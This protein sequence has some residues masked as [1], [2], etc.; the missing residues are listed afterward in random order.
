MVVVKKSRE[1]QSILQTVKIDEHEYE[2]PV[3]D[4]VT[5][6]RLFPRRRRGPQHLLHRACELWPR[7]D[8]SRRFVDCFGNE[9]WEFFH[10]R[11]AGRLRVALTLTTGS[12]W[13]PH[14]DHP[15]PPRVRA[16]QGVPAAGHGLFLDRTALVDDSAEI[17]LAA[18][19]LAATGATGAELMEAI[20]GWVYERMRF[21]TGVTT[22]STPA[23]AALAGGEG[24]CQDYTHL[25][26]AICR[27]LDLPARY[28]SGFIPCEGAM[29]AWVE[30]LVPD[31]RTGTLHWEG[32][33]PTHN[34]RPDTTYLTVAAGR[35]YADICPNSGTFRGLSTHRVSAWCET[36]EV[37][38]KGEW[39][40]GSGQWAAGSHHSPQIGAWKR[41]A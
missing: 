39:S 10:S 11:L 6:L 29:H 27:S 32:F 35:D 38:S 13:Q 21:R 1:I 7:P 22:V 33:D 34:R 30:A 36:V 5:R 23:S 19:F 37:I 12:L 15:L 2:A 41:A 20:G 14:P 3:R 17:R 4:V 18:H 26:L 9:V 40:V 28:V 24:V 8:R 16:S 25:M 31:P